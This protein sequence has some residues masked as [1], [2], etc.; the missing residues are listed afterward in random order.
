MIDK[1]EKALNS[2]AQEIRNNRE[3]FSKLYIT[4]FALA[5]ARA[6]AGLAKDYTGSYTEC[7]GFLLGSANK[8]SRL[9]D[10]VYFAPGQ[11]VN[12]AH[13]NIPSK[14]VIDAG[15]YIREK[16]QLK[17]ILGWWHSHANFGTFHSGTDDENLITVLNQI[18]PTNYVNLYEEREF[19][20]RDIK[21]TK[22]GDSVIYV[23]DKNNTSKR[24]EMIFSDL[25]ENPLIG[26]SVEKLKIRVPM[27][28]SYAYSMVVNAIGSRPYVEVATRKLCPT[29]YASEDEHKVVPMKVLTTGKFR[30]NMEKLEQEVNEKLILPAPSPK[31]LNF[32]FGGK[33]YRKGEGFQGKKW[34]KIN[35][36]VVPDD[37]ILE[38][39][40]NE[41]GR[42]PK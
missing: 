28:V 14:K 12:A 30:L 23:C 39:G 29:C 18:A 8:K 16:K 36:I 32:L 5:K 13:V 37:D 33:A 10:D 27:K 20:N 34:R 19:L 31:F 4:D 24:L 42:S 6:Y 2:D 41:N 15:S 38:P 22:N 1:L 21:K 17:R 26:T 11:E 35:E 3:L 7:Y 9:V 40:E 25:E